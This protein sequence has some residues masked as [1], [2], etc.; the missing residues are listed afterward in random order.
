[1]IVVDGKILFYL[2]E[3]LCNYEF[4]FFYNIYF[5]NNKEREEVGT[6]QKEKLLI[7][8]WVSEKREEEEKVMGR[9]DGKM[10]KRGTWYNCIV[11][12]KL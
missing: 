3:F 10:R 4:C 12:V 7:G 2:M 11:V 5:L 8:D 1:M 6:D 9:Y